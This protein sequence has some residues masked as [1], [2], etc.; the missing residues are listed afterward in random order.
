M[1]SACVHWILYAC[2]VLLILCSVGNNRKSEKWNKWESKWKRARQDKYTNKTV[3]QKLLNDIH[4]NMVRIM[5]TEMNGKSM[6]EKNQSPLLWMS[7]T[8]NVIGIYFFVLALPFAEFLWMYIIS[9]YV[10]V[11]HW[12]HL[13]INEVS[14][15]RSKKHRWKNHDLHVDDWIDWRI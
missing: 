7:N 2:R 5:W 3:R 11:I 4:K 15:S 13:Q 12:Y 6:Y 14:F 10:I 9:W 1:Q 8:E